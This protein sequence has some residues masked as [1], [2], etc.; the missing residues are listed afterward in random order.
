[1]D[2]KLVCGTVPWNRCAR[3]VPPEPFHGTVPPEPFHGTV[4]RELLPET[5]ASG[6]AVTGSANG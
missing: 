5:K 1:M 2:R 6:P 3:D 4:V